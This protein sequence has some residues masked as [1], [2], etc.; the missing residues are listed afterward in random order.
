MLRQQLEA[1]HAA[2]TPVEAEAIIDVARL[3]A[4][5]DKRSDVPETTMLLEIAQTLTEMA[6]VTDGM[7]LSEATIDENRL[8]S[9]GESLVPMGARELAF[10]CAFLVMIQDLDLTSEERQ[11][12]GMLG[13]AL[14]LD[15]ARSKQ[16]AA[17][18]ETY[19]RSIR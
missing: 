17:E 18:M 7:Q 16:L 2:L 9:I 15:P 14:V 3:A 13:D 12:A 8:L 6:G 4:S 1:I 11:L 5:V 10:A 19:A